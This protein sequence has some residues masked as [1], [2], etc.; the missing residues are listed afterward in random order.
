MGQTTESTMEMTGP[1]SGKTPG[2]GTRP[3]ASE[4]TTEA[5]TRPEFSGR[6]VYGTDF[7]LINTALVSPWYSFH[8]SLRQKYQIGRIKIRGIGR[9]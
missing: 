9:F 6:L 3:T 1:R 8:L 5:L 2:E 4:S 7:P